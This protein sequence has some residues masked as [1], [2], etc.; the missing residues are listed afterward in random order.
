MPS[1]IPS[2]PVPPPVTPQGTGP[3]APTPNFFVHQVKWEGETVSIIAIWYTGDIE[4]WKVLSTVNPNL[5]PNLIHVGDRI[6][7]PQ[8][9]MK[10]KEPMS[11]EF[12]LDFLPK[13]KKEPPLEREK[14]LEL[15][16]PKGFRTK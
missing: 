7:I 11:K 4:N 3:S 15:F 16:G 13:A 5:N 2:M 6:F 14:E 9:L 10:T 1:T 12:V 8:E